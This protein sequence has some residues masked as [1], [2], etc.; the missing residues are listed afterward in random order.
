MARVFMMVYETELK[1]LHFSQMLKFCLGQILSQMK[2]VQMFDVRY[3]LRVFKNLV[4]IMAF[5]KYR[6]IIVL[7]PKG[8]HILLS[9]G[10]DRLRPLLRG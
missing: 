3:S 1:R 4:P 10:L 8:R 9:I 7:Y 6:A 2:V 5:W